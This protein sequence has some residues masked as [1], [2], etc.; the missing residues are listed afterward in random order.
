[1]KH[2][3]LAQIVLQRDTTTNTVPDNNGRL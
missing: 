2:R 1:M 3:V